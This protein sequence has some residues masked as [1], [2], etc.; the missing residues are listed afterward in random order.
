MAIT[1]FT[2]SYQNSNSTTQLKLRKWQGK[3]TSRYSGVLCSPLNKSTVI[4]SCFKFSTLNVI[5]TIRHGADSLRV[6]SITFGI[7]DFQKKFKKLVKL[8]QLFH[9]NWVYS[10]TFG[11]FE[12]HRVHVDYLK[13]K[14]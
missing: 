13:M 8:Q 14:I 3:D 2:N 1:F 5:C 10:I 7:F 4:S 11:M 12:F 9:Q 6:Y